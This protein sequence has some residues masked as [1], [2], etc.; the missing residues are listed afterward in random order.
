MADE[1]TPKPRWKGAFEYYLDDDPEVVP[2]DLYELTP[3][4]ESS[5]VDYRSLQSVCGSVPRTLELWSSGESLR[6]I[7]GTDSGTPLR[8]FSQ[9][10]EGLNYRALDEKTREPRFI[11]EHDLFLSFDAELNHALPYTFWDE[12]HKILD[13]LSAAI[14]GPAWIQLAFVDY[15]WSLAAE[16][17]GMGLQTFYEMARRSPHPEIAGSTLGEHGRKIGMEFTEKAHKPGK[18]LHIRGML[19]VPRELPPS[20]YSGEAIQSVLEN[21]SVHFDN[22][23][24]FGYGGDQV[25]RVHTWMRSRNVPDPTKFIEMN[26]QILENSPEAGMPRWGHGRELIPGFPL[27]PEELTYFLSLPSKASFS[28]GKVK[29]ERKTRRRSKGSGGKSSRGGQGQ[30]SAEEI[31][32]VAG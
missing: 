3:P 25:A 23:A 14:S 17:A 12:D 6:I 10:Y 28:R 7:L 31:S 9:A 11:S 4:P 16:R 19:P 8:F 32:E 15:D 22:V 2:L 27:T 13:R 1:D 21:L 24:I 29:A 30:P 5:S 20:S 18:F 26:A